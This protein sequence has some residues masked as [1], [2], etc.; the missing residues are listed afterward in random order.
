MGLCHSSPEDNEKTSQEKL[1]KVVSQE[2]D[3]KLKDDQAI[4]QEINK[5]LLLGAGE[6]GKSTL[7][8]QMNTIY[9]GGFP[10]EDRKNFE[11]I[12]YNNIIYSMQAL[13]TASQL[14]TIGATVN[15]TESLAYVKALG[16]DGA[17]ESKNVHHFKNLWSD[18][19][20]Q[21]TYEHRSK[22]Q[23]NDSAKYFFDQLDLIATPGYIPTEQ[24]VL[25]SRVRTLGIV[26]N[27]FEIDGNKFKMFDVGGQRN[28]RKKWIHCFENVT[29]V[30]FVGV[31]SEYDQV[32]YEDAA[33]N[34]MVET[35]VLFE[36]ICNSPW[37][38]ETAVILFL[39]K[40]DMF[41]DKIKKV[42]LTVCPIFVN[43]T[44]PQDYHTGVEAIEEA[45]QAKNHNREKV[46]Y[47][48][49][50]CATDTTNVAAVFHAVKDI[51]IRRALGDAGLV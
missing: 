19:G 34:R 4:D 23:L 16:Q 10:E 13:V 49:V 43:F 26:E 8:K 36:E 48:H 30:L 9:G 22:F 37:F 21:L 40:R 1:E 7:F 25:R 46:I 32:L 12:I 45:F 20:I 39:N 11:Y 47:S 2:Q 17:I 51:I 33:V 42:S 38:K 18:P 27:A 6:S 14:P 5:L 50:T 3:K 41:E 24:D 29:A 35:L 15:C 31:L 44:G 28:E